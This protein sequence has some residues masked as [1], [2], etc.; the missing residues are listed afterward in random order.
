[1]GV[2][3][4]GNVPQYEKQAL[5]A[6]ESGTAQPALVELTPLPAHLTASAPRSSQEGVMN[7][8][9]DSD[10]DASPHLSHVT[11]EDQQSAVSGTNTP[12][13]QSHLSPLSQ[14][15]YVHLPAGHATSDQLLGD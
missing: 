10:G 5:Q 9:H 7:W 8:L 11:E 2:W 6:E 1:M 15:G 14:N 3:H 4:A 12:N 13:P